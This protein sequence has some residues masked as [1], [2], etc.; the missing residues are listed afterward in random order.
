[1]GVS[2]VTNMLETNDDELKE[3]I[4]HVPTLAGITET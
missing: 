1:M 4:L 2:R 3:L